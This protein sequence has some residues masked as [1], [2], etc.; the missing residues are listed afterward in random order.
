M[1]VFTKKYTITFED[2]TDKLELKNISLMKYLVDAA[3]MH[4]ETVGYGLSTI[5][6]THIGFLLVGWKVKILENP[7][8]LDEIEIRTWAE[9]LSHSLSV[10]NFEVYIKDKLVALAS[11]KWIMVN[12]KD[13]SV[14]IVTEEIENA[15][16]PVNKKVFDEPIPKLRIPEKVDKTKEYTIERRDIDSNKHVNNLKYLEIALE[17]LSDDDYS[18]TDFSEITVNY[19]NE[20][21]LHHDVLCSY[22]KISDFEHVIVVQSIDKTKLHAIIKLK[23]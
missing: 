18:E 8:L 12:P 17:L 14:A 3:G 2:V 10:R 16:G 11:T 19:K 13:H 15:Y 21:K 7:H 6:K 20:C 22:T 9:N 5:D 23:K 1:G 4:S